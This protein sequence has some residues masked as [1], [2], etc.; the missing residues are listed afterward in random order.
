MKPELRIDR[1]PEFDAPGADEILSRIASAIRGVRFGAVEIVIQDSR[2]VQIERKEKF[3]FD[4]P[5]RF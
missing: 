4:K 1:R 5:S 3:R 2:V